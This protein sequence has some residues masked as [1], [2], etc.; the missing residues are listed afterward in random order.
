MYRGICG[1]TFNCPL[2]WA[3]LKINTKFITINTTFHRRGSQWIWFPTVCPKFEI[4]IFGMNI[5]T[6]PVYIQRPISNILH[7]FIFWREFFSWLTGR[8]CFVCTKSSQHCFFEQ[9]F[10][11]HSNLLLYYIVSG[12]KYYCLNLN[13]N[14]C[15]NAT[16]VPVWLLLKC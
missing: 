11:C 4:F 16:L 15:I 12:C 1:S 3:Q 5:Q 9:V 10:I 2:R 8:P 7:L 13:D 14:I 6:H